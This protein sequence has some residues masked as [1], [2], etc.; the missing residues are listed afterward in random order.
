MGCLGNT[1]KI[2]S[3]L[4][5]AT[6]AKSTV[7][8]RYHKGNLQA[9]FKKNKTKKQRLCEIC[10]SVRPSITQPQAALPLSHH[11]YHAPQW[12]LSSC[13]SMLFHFT[14]LEQRAD[15]GLNQ[16]VL[17]NPL[18]NGAWWQYA[19]LP[20]QKATLS[21]TWTW[22]LWPISF[23]YLRWRYLLSSFLKGGIWLILSPPYY[24]F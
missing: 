2:P 19:L 17:G 24:F 15:T 12:W 11:H 8:L 4:S 18:P 7:H 10:F 6:Y 21:R 1:S 20:G 16:L 9:E 5:A 14:K 23:S 13:W 22:C 3:S